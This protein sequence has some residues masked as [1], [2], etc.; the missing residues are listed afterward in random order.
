[1]PSGELQAKKTHCPQGH[2][3]TEQNTRYQN[4]RDRGLAR[5]SRYCRTCDRE[6]MQR[7][8][9]DPKVQEQ[10]RLRMAQWRKRNPEQNRERWEKSHREK[11]AILDKAR[12]GGCVRCGE[13][14]PS[15]LDFHHRDRATKDADIATMRRFGLSR[16][17]DEIAKC[18]VLCANCHRKFH[19]DE[20][21]SAL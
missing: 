19:Y 16:L 1:M 5:R 21:N 10:G 17:V 3:Y 13:S 20:R 4:K 11:K 18:D 7:K 6:R 9:L 15:C 14:H 12:S 8:R 2:E